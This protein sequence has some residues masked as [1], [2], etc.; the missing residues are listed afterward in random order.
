AGGAATPGEGVALPDGNRAGGAAYRRIPGRT[1]AHNAGNASAKY[2]ARITEGKAGFSIAAA[3]TA[4][5][6]WTGQSGLLF[7]IRLQALSQRRR[8]G[9]ALGHCLGELRQV[10]RLITIRKRSLRIGMDLE[11][12]PIGA[13]SD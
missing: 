11:D 4:A 1:G 9:P 12:Q 8:H 7:S 13:G 10:Q 6:R 3:L 5:S 2:S